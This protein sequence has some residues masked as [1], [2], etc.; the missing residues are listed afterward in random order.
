MCQQLEVQTYRTRFPEAP[1]GRKKAHTAVFLSRER[2]TSSTY[3]GQL[4]EPSTSF[5]SH[6]EKG[7]VERH[8]QTSQNHCPCAHHLPEDVVNLHVYKHYEEAGMQG[9]HRMSMLPLNMTWPCTQCFTT[10][11]GAQVPVF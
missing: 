1:K 2:K 7:K 3:K 8:Q 10:V 11:Q 5:V 9:T 6:A 4:A